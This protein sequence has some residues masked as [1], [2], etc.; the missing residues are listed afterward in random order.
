MEELE[1]E[2]VKR[3][4]IQKW[5]VRRAATMATDVRQAELFSSAV[6]LVA[7]NRMAQ[8]LHM[9]S[10]LMRS[11]GLWVALHQ[12]EAVESFDNFVSGLCGLARRRVHNNARSVMGGLGERRLD[13]VTVQSRLAFH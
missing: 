4:P 6:D 3:L 1:T 10:D 12:R 5:L 2:G 9:H 7:D 11:P 8:V 13:P